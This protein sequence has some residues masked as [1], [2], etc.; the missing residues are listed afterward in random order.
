MIIYIIKPYDHLTTSSDFQTES[1]SYAKAARL[2]VSI[3][4]YESLLHAI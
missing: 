3:H 1:L 2:Y 4:S